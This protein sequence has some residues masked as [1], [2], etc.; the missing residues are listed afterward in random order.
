MFF[1]LKRDEWQLLSSQLKEL[2]TVFLSL[3]ESSKPLNMLLSVQDL[4]IARSGQVLLA[5]VSFR[6]DKG[7]AIILKGPNGLG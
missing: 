4:C 3:I 6:L 1:Y 2:N 5:D 7:Q